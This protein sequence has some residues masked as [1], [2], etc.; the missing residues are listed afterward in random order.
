MQHAQQSSER[1]FCVVSAHN[2][3][4]RQSP[5]AFNNRT[6]AAEAQDA[7]SRWNHHF[8]SAPDR[9]FELRAKSAIRNTQISYQVHLLIVRQQSMYMMNENVRTATRPINSVRTLMT[10]QAMEKKSTDNGST[11]VRLLDMYSTL[12]QHATRTFTIPKFCPQQ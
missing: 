12:R 5:S 11:M 7:L 1:C 10:G 9:E 2:I 8:K 4:R 3:S 6:D